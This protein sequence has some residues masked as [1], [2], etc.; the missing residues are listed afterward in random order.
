[1]I[2]AQEFDA[3][4]KAGEPLTR[5]EMERLL[6]S[7]NL[8]EVG[9]L[10]ET[11]RKAR[12]GDV[13][14]YGRVGSDRGQTGVRP[15]SDRGSTGVR[16]G[17]DGGQTPDPGEIR[18]TGT[19]ASASEAR[20]RVR[21]AAAWSKGI[22]LTGYSLGDLIELVSGDHLALAELAAAL[23]SDGLESVADVPL[24]AIGDTEN[25]IEVVRAVNHGGLGAWRATV[26]AADNL[27]TRLDLIARAADVQRETS[28]FR[29]FAPLPSVDPP[30]SPGTGFDDVR[31]VAAARLMSTIPAIQ[32]DWSQYG[33][34]L[35]QVA[36]TYGASDIDG[37]N[38]IDDQSLGARRSPVEDIERQI[39]AAFAVPARRNGRYERLS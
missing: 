22:P 20:E 35:A 23:R 7:P 24:D 6:V 38:P 18:L 8:V 13:V 36:I 19:P 12:L 16:P 2:S 34:K 10:A 17:S 15:G 31:T 29:A 39:R 25:A 37:I 3:R 27:A 33:P 28:A 30:A 14:T 1:M 11:A 5:A 26:R 9:A 32:L 21:A 4:V